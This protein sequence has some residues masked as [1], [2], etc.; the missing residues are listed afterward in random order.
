LRFEDGAHSGT[1]NGYPILDI[2]GVEGMTAGNITVSG[3]SITNQGTGVAIWVKRSGTVIENV[4]VSSTG[5]VSLWVGIADAALPSYYTD[6]VTVRGVRSYLTAA[7]AHGIMLGGG[8]RRPLVERCYSMNTGATA[9]G[10]V[11]KSI[12][13]IVQDSV[14][15]APSGTSGGYLWKGAQRSTVRRNVIACAVANA[16]ALRTDKGTRIGGAGQDQDA[17]DTITFTDNIVCAGSGSLY[18]FGA[19]SYAGYAATGCRFSGAAGA[20]APDQST[21][22]LTTNAWSTAGLPTA[23]DDLAQV[24]RPAVSKRGQGSCGIGF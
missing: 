16:V 19:G 14:F 7:S 8:S 13:G 24:A 20:N 9:Y 3:G 18:S 21:W 6:D 10:F 17:V 11:D 23:T 2:D 4:A 5:N 15:I 1:L 22:P 12:D